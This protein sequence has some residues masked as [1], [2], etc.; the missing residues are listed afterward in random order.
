MVS[1]ISPEEANI[2]H[3]ERNINVGNHYFMFLVAREYLNNVCHNNVTESVAMFD[4][5]IQRTLLNVR[6]SNV[7]LTCSI[8]ASFCSQMIAINVDKFSSDP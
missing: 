6:E 1:W 5:R 4:K 8:D 3:T 7:F 2:N